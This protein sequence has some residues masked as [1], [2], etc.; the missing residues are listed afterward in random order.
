MLISN[1]IIYITE[2]EFSIRFSLSYYTEWE[3]SM[4]LI[5]HE[6]EGRVLYQSHTNLPQSVVWERENLI[7]ND[8]SVIYM[9][10]QTKT[11]WVRCNLRL[12][13]VTFSLKMNLF[14]EF[15]MFCCEFLLLF[16]YRTKGFS[17]YNCLVSVHLKFDTKQL[18]V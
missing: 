2:Q 12:N 6:S 11:T 18:T 15:L 1:T 9:I 16:I 5:Q 7:L 14:M 10:C 13:F 8:C 17:S 3:V 4:R